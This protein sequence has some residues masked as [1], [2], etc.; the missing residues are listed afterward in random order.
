LACISTTS[1]AASS[2]F[3][4]SGLRRRGSGV[5]MVPR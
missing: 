1:K 2:R 5:V 4:S 3:I